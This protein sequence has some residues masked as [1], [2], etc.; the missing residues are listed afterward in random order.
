MP[1]RG[2]RAELAHYGAPAAFL[3]AVTIAVLLVRTGLR[4]D[5]P[6]PGATTTTV[7]S[8]APRGGQTATE[9]RSPAR[10]RRFYR[11]R[12]GDTLESV[13]ARFDTSVD[14]L[15]AVNPGLDPTALRIGQRVRVA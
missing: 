13:A 7:T 1:R 15:L 11:I 3:A 4:E 5:D 10:Q 2:W 14:R 6:D 8:P 12:D 9:P